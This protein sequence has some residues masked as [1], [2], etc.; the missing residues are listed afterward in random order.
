M[1]PPFSDDY[2]LMCESHRS[3]WQVNKGLEHFSEVPGL[4][5][6]FIYSLNLS[7]NNLSE[8]PPLLF[9]TMGNLK[10]LSVSGNMLKSLPNE[11][12]NCK[13]LVTL[14]VSEN[15]LTKLPH[16]L[17]RCQELTRLDIDKNNFAE[18]P[19]VVLKLKNLTRLYAQHLQL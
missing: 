4:Y 10:D 3:S 8:L 6:Q 1:L 17:K 7:G 13:Q 16:S 5:P 14:S 18:F 11:I 19:G 2:L 12:G 9:T 15:C